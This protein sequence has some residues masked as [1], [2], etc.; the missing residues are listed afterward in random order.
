MTTPDFEYAKFDLLKSTILG[1]Y[2]D[3]ARNYPKWVRNTLKIC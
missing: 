2:M 1:K 3:M